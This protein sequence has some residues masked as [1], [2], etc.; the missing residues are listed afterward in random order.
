MVRALT[1]EEHPKETSWRGFGIVTSLLV[2]TLGLTFATLSASDAAGDPP[3]V[4]KE[5]K[6][7]L[8][9]QACAK[10]GQKAAKDA[11]KKFNKLGG[12]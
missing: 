10:G 1:F 9:K 2:I 12:K 5:P 7:E 6:T 4:V 8:V 11:T 3:C